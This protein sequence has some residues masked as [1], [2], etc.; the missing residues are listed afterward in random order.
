MSSFEPNTPS[1][2]PLHYL[3]LTPAIDYTSSTTK[4]ARMKL[5]LI[6]ASLIALSVAA[7]AEPPFVN[8]PLCDMT[9]NARYG[10]C[11]KVSHA[12]SC[13]Q[14]S[15]SYSSLTHIPCFSTEANSASNPTRPFSRA[16][17]P[18]R[19]ASTMAKWLVLQSHSAYP[20]NDTC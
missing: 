3:K 12:G 6:L 14:L 1:H 9:C 5:T 8:S 7:L 13:S 20:R 4:T 15:P 19:P 11:V 17:A 10:G 18:V 16:P 2:S